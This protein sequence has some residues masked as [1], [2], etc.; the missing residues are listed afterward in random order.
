[1]SH[2]EL[3]D[4]FL[5]RREKMSNLRD[6]GIDPFGQRFER[7]HTSQ[8]L[9]SEY[10]EL[11][12]EQLEENEVPVSLAGRIMTKRGK[13]KAG[14]AHVQDLTGQIQLYVRKDAIGEE[15][16]EIFSSVDIG[17][18]VGVEG[19]LFKTKVGE[20]SIKVKDFTL[21]TKALR[22]LPDKYH[23]LKDIEQRYRQRYLDLI[24]NPESKQTFISRSRIIQSMRRYLDNHGYLEV[25]TPMMHSIAG[26]AAARP[27]VTHHNAL[28]M[29]LYMR[30]A[31]E[32][33][34]KR[35]IVG[36]LEKVYEIGRVFRNEGVSTRHNPEFTMIELYE[37]Y[38]DY[39]DIMALTENLIAHI[40][41][42]VLGTTKI[43]YG[44]QEVDLTPEW[45]RLHMVDAIK[46]YTGVDF[47]GETSVEEA[48]ALAKEHGVEITEHMQYGHIVN[49]FFEQKVEE[50]L[51]QPTFIY[52]HPVEISPLAK[53]NAEDPRFTDR[54]ELFIVA[55]EHANAFTELNDPIDQRE[56]FEAQ[57]KEKEQGNDEAHEMDD[58]F[59]EALEYGMPPTGGL[60]IGIDRLVML[61]TNA[62]S[63]RDVLLFPHMRQR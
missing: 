9:I 12:K 37:A 59:I 42:E 52:G 25:E 4:Q 6:Q 63:I 31:I 48:R 13:G 18:L 24:T 16:Y 14:F 51:I 57:L 7:T 33:H 10:D 28:D 20:L 22:P 21:L 32:L 55:R 11:T 29:E 47:W 41:Q 60:G 3:N 40:A 17:D 53:K 26:G 39:K 62:P 1:M 45:T 54:F 19:V 5:V 44:D 36:G 43:Q 8:Q 35:L 27:F 50:Q 49:E 30:I 23:G 58:D 56:R 61:L 2:E 46:Q 34:L 38:A 15:Q